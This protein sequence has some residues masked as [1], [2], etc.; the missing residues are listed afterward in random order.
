MPAFLGHQYE[1]QCSPNRNIQGRRAS[2][3]RKIIQNRFCSFMQM[4]PGQYGRFSITEV[5]CLDL[6]RYFWSLNDPDPGFAFQG[7]YRDIIGSSEQQLIGHGVRYRYL[8][9][10]QSEEVHEPSPGQEDER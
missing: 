10:C 2:T 3:G 4:S 6:L 8:L 9:S 7:L 5:P 1:S